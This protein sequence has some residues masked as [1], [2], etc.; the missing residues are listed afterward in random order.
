VLGATRMLDWVGPVAA[1]TGAPDR[2]DVFKLTTHDAVDVAAWHHPSRRGGASNDRLAR[3]ARLQPLDPVPE[4]H[5]L[6]DEVARRLTARYPH[7]RFTRLAASQPMAQA[8][9][10]R[11]ALSALSKSPLLVTAGASAAA[12]EIGAATHHVLQHLDFRRPCDAGDVSAQV[13]ELVDRRL[14]TSAEA[15]RVDVETL[16]WLAKSE[17]GALLREHWPILRRELPVYAAAPV[18][19]GADQVM[20]RGRVDVLLPLPD[21]SILIDYKTDSVTAGQV[22]VRAELY[23]PQTAAYAGAVERIAGKPVDV[24]LVFLR[25]RVIH[26]LR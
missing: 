25:P 21:R 9:G 5:P 15:A 13:N 16:V 26:S 24:V 11:K 4:A 14:L 10:E 6:A 1:A 19:E 8:R 3:L 22:A 23:R 20:L 12:D 2:S 7:E 17:V 18:G